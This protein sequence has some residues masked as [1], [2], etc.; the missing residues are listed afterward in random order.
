MG[1]H[2]TDPWVC[3]AVIVGLALRFINLG[4]APLWFDETF[5]FQHLVIPWRGWLAE[6]IRDNQ[7]PIYY[8]LAKAWTGFAGLSPFD[9]RMPGL[10]A[11]VACIPLAAAVTRLLAGD[12]SARVA[13]G[14]TAISP[15]LIQHA[16]DARP[17]ALLS[18][19]ALAHL[20]LLARFVVGR[21]PRLGF[22]WASL[23]LAVVATHY[24]GIFFLAG[25]GLALLLLWR[26][27]LST[28]LPAGLVTG[29]CCGVLVLAAAR[30]ASGAFAGEYVF[31][32][33]AVPGVIWSM[34]TGYTLL[35]TSEQ[36]HA[37]GPSAILPDLPVALA[38]LPAFAIVALAGLRALDVPGRIV[39]LSTFC[40]AL[41]LPFLYRLA[42]GAG[43]HPRYFAAAMGPLLIVM[44]IGM[45]LDRSRLA[46]TASTVVLTLVMVYATVL[47][48]RDT[49]HGR[50]DVAA[51]GRWLDA[52][53]P[54]DEEIL[55]TSNEMEVLA[56][57]HWPNRRFRSFPAGKGVV[58]AD[59][60]PALVEEFPFPGGRR[61]IF[62][63]GRAW[64]TD[65]EGRLQTA[66]TERYAEC[67]GTDVDGI[68]IHC[69]QPAAGSAMAASPQ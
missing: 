40:T 56:R 44:A 48:L 34:L 68:R 31:G 64:L 20:L 22:W 42:A 51:A 12:R 3:A 33:T 58:T 37:L 38:A 46:R 59:R 28:W 39:V 49:G 4:S 54:P 52:N 43:V 16:Q 9:M 32:V 35:P 15:Y 13:A 41:L 18:A 53:V 67:P 55:I 63:V 47:H 11:S 29:V 27:P 30:N 69:F 10:I 19:L 2:R 36:L 24:Y 57:F 17:Y 61:S 26:R 62:V 6:V 50:E 8:A 1:Q 45:S 5:T 7:A 66:L 14:L 65:P 21:S 60:I 25:Q 23:A